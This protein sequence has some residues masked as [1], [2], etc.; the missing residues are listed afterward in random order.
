MQQTKQMVKKAAY[1]DSE[2]SVLS[3]RHAG[4]VCN[5]ED[6]LTAGG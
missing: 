3:S 5:V 6:R 4:G 1:D 2:T